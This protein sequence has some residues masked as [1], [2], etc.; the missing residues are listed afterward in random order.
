MHC[1]GTGTGE[2][3]KTKQMEIGNFPIG[4][5]Y[6]KKKK[7]INNRGHLLKLFLCIPS[8]LFWVLNCH[9]SRIGNIKEKK[10]EKLTTV[11]GVFPILVPSPISLLPFSFQCPHITAPWIL[12]KVVSCI[13]CETQGGVIYSILTGITLLITFFEQLAPMKNYESALHIVF[14][15]I[16]KEAINYPYLKNPPALCETG[17]QS[18]G[19][20]DPLE[21][22]KATH[23]FWPG[24]FHGL[25]SPWGHKESDMTER[26]SLMKIVTVPIS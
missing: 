21:K 8:R 20:E 11:W 7:K 24:E 22:G 12:S 17:I 23:S 9:W 15:L 25:Y 1:L 6:L 18:L 26:F 16:L 14:H 5:K 13:Q 4:A 19:W 10:M 2:K 3:G